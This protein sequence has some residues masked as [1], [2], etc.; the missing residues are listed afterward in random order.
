VARH[1]LGLRELEKEHI[2]EA[3]LWDAQ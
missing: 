1:Y 3:A 2:L